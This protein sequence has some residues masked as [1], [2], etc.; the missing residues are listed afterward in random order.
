MS[1][2]HKPYKRLT[3]AVKAGNL[4][5]LSSFFLSF[6][7]IKKLQDFLV[8]VQLL[9]YSHATIFHSYELYVFIVT[10]NVFIK[11][12]IYDYKVYYDNR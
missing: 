9:W 3:S 7:K 11:K 2:I 10:E 6:T 8:F 4:Y 1:I 12:L 5:F